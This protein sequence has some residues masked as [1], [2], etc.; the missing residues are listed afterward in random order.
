MLVSLT[1]NWGSFIFVKIVEV[2]THLLIPD[3]IMRLGLHEY[4]M[5]WRLGKPEWY[6]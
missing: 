4:S 3:D 5:E 2:E 1:M 6:H